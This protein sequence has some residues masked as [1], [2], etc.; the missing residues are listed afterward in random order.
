[1]ELKAFHN[2]EDGQAYSNKGSIQDDFN[3]TWNYIYTGT[4]LAMKSKV[5]NKNFGTGLPTRL[6]CIPI[7][8]T[9]LK[10][11]KLEDYD[12]YDFERESRMKE[13]A[14]LLDRTKGELK[15]CELLTNIHL[16]LS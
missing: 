1:M 4:P 16:L 13:W 2:E 7:P 5:N 15:L 10:M 6:T 14:S 11:M 3:V 9:N 12:H 8:A